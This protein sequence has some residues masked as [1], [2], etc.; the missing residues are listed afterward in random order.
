MSRAGRAPQRCQQE[1]LRAFMRPL[2]T[3]LHC[4]PTAR[5]RRV[6]TAMAQLE[7]LSMG[8]RRRFMIRHC[9]TAQRTT[10]LR[11]TYSAVK[12]RAALPCARKAKSRNREAR[13]RSAPLQSQRVMLSRL[14][15][16]TRQTLSRRQWAAA[17]AR[18]RY[19]QLS[20]GQLLRRREPQMQSAAIRL[21]TRLRRPSAVWPSTM[22]ATS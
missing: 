20:I 12:A 5:A 16:G 17:A 18:N 9:T 1:L 7:I 10:R 3:Q 4:C 2:R 19:R 22:C 6:A 21:A 14:A 11:Q 15:A 13:R 8:R